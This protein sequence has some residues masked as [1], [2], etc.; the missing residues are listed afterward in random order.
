M[1]INYFYVQIYIHLFVLF[2]GKAGVLGC[3]LLLVQ[4]TVF[5]CNPEEVNN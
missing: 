4:E 3:S 1:R 5:V 2:E